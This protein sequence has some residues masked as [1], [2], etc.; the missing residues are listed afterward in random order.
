MGL[1]GKET[2]MTRLFAATL[3]TTVLLL[4]LG[5]EDAAVSDGS[6][7]ALDDRYAPENYTIEI[8]FVEDLLEPYVFYDEDGCER[9]SFEYAIY[10]FMDLLMQCIDSESWGMYAVIYPFHGHLVI[11]QTAANHQA[12]AALLDQMRAAINDP[13]IQQRRD[14][15]PR[16]EI[17]FVCGNE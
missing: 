16:G 13:E 3:L 10:D 7:A 11:K 15:R 1:P 17:P 4:T 5:C 2:L 14:S 12:I 9:I 6:S 8:Y